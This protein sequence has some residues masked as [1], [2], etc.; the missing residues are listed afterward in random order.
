MKE[1]SI[2]HLNV[3]NF[4][5]AVAGALNPRLRS[6][7]VVVATAGSSRRVVLDLSTVAYEA[8]VRR[9]MVLERACRRCRDIVVLEPTPVLYERA[10]RALFD[11]AGRLS[12]RVEQAGPGHLFV[13]LSGTERLWGDPVDRSVALQ[14]TFK[15]KFSLDPAVGVA[16]NK[17]MSKVATRVIKPTGLCRVVPG[18][19]G[20][21]LAPLPVRVL[22]GLD[23]WIIEHTVQFNISIINDLVAISEPQLRSVFGPLGSDIYRRARGIDD[24]PV[25]AIREPAPVVVES[26]VFKGQTNDSAVVERELFNLVTKAGV[27][28]RKMHVAAR[29][30]VLTMRYS[31]G[32]RSRRTRRLLE[33]LD[34]DLSLFRHFL[35]LLHSGNTRRIRL[36]DITIE[37]GELCFPYGDGG[38]QLDLFADS[39]WGREREARL[40]QALDTLRS[41]FGHEA[42]VFYGRQRAEG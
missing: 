37:L 27:R 10:H 20:D 30:I 17:L 26:V 9:G 16:V 15:S 8:G 13:D 2:I 33:P 19:E 32:S 29:K 42:V 34:T 7:P 11:E 28:A 5:V 39:D 25:R 41:S 3:A 6:Y 22:P 18:C 14:R 24:S 38:Y 23:E 21:F 40:T 12:P 31:D 4:Y 35:E 36:N 1:R